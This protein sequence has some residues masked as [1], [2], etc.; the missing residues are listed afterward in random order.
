MV[1]FLASR[2]HSVLCRALC[3]SSQRMQQAEGAGVFCIFLWGW[4]SLT[5]QVEVFVF[6]Q[7]KKGGLYFTAVRHMPQADP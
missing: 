1:A 7:A 4:C 5:S 6:Y 3:V 2:S